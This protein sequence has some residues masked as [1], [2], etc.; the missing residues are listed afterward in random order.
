M[1]DTF[2]YTLVVLACELCPQILLDFVC[3]PRDL[4]TVPPAI[5]EGAPIETEEALEVFAGSNEGNESANAVWDAIETASF[6]T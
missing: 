2:T 3:S 4:Y 1:Y 5:V 6:D